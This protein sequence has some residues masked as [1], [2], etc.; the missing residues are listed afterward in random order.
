MSRWPSTSASSSPGRAAS[1]TCAPSTRGSPSTR[2][3]PPR[4]RGHRRGHRRR[5]GIAT[6]PLGRRSLV[7]TFR[8]RPRRHPPPDA[9]PAI[10]CS[11]PRATPTSAAGCGSSRGP[12]RWRGGDAGRFRVLVVDPAVSP[13]PIRTSSE[14]RSTRRR[15]RLR[16]WR[17]ERSQEDGVPAYVVLH[18]ATLREL[19]APG[20][21]RRTSSPVKGSGRQGRALRGRTARRARDGVLAQLS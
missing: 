6:W 11:R 5:G 4:C 19:A 17:L 21:R 13:P 16:S 7:A 9:P 18:D 2:A 20:L 10:A 8:G 12:A 15:R 14:T 3:L 1:A